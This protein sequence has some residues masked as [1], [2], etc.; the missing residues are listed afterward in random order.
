MPNILIAARRRL[1][2]TLHSV[3]KTNYSVVQV[4]T[5]TEAIRKLE[6]ESFDL[7]ICGTQFDDGGLFSFIR[8][9]RKKERSRTTPIICIRYLESSLA[10]SLQESVKQAVMIAGASAYLDANHLDQYELRQL[11]DKLLFAN[12]ST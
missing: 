3:L 11:M 9:V 1:S 6:L 4:A 10:D 5:Q 8:Q 7:I 2:N 12:V